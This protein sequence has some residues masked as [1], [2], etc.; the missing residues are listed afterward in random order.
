MEYV[1]YFSFTFNRSAL[2]VRT[3]RFLLLYVKCYVSTKI[4]KIS[5]SVKVWSLYEV[6]LIRGKGCN[7]LYAMLK[8][9]FLTTTT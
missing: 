9:G 2:S 5:L 7:E 1:R 4:T 8:L 3:A 6:C